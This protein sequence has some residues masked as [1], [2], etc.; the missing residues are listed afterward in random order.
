MKACQ[1]CLW[2]MASGFR[3]K[4]VAMTAKTPIEIASAIERDMDTSVWMIVMAR[5]HHR[6]PVGSGGQGYEA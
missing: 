6:V 4:P 1:T 3:K 5:R 2:K